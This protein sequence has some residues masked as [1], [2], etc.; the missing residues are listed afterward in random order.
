[1]PFLACTRT[2]ALHHP[3]LVSFAPLPVSDVEAAIYQGCSKGKWIPTK[4]RD[5]EIEATLYLRNHVAVVDIDYDANA[6]QVRYVRSENLNFKN[7]GGEEVIHPNYNAWVKN[8]ISNIETALN[9]RS[10][11]VPMRSAR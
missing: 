10:G 9:E 6:F 4:I 11:P 2:A 3:P 8:L 5:G 1:M 7:R